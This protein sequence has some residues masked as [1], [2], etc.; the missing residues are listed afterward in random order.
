MNDSKPQKVLVVEDEPT[1]SDA[2][3]YALRREGYECRAVTD[4]RQVERAI[5]AFG[6]RV[7]ILDVM[8]PGVDGFSILRGFSLD[9]PFGVILVTARDDITDKVTGLELGADDYLTKPFDMRELLARVRSLFRRISGP[10]VPLEEP[11]IVWGDVV[12]DGVQ[13]EA[14]IN[15]VALTLTP[16]EFDL[17]AALLAHPGRVFTREQLLESVWGFDYIGATRTVDI[18]IQ[19]L[20][21]K[22]AEGLRNSQESP[23]PEI[24]HTVHGVGYKA[25]KAR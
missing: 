10:V 21:K 5:Q 13:R 16:K 9:R 8:L 17:A 2:I 18:H 24:F 3:L 1:I 11:T 14:R 19:R 20:R 22:F 25:L 7:V 6:P 4:G 23:E 15:G 12:L